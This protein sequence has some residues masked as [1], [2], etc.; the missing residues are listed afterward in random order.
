MS[1]SVRKEK[2]VFDTAKLSEFNFGDPEAKNDPL[3]E[4]CPLT[5]KGVKEFLSGAK[6]IVLGERGVGK[7][8]L[9]KL[10]SEGI[11]NFSTETPEKKKPRKQIIVAI[12]DD[13]EYQ[14]IANVV[15]ERFE[16]Q[17]KKKF[18]KNRLFWEI[19]IL[20]KTIAK[21]LE[22]DSEN[23]ELT[24][25]L[26][27]F[28]AVLGVTVVEG[29]SIG[30][31]LSSLKLTGGVKLDQAGSLTPTLSVES[32]KNGIVPR[33]ITDHEINALRDRVVKYLKPRNYSVIVMIDKIDDFVVGLDYENQKL[34]I[35]ALLECVQC[36]NLPQIKLK[37]FLRA[38]LF[39]RMNFETT[40]Y[41][42]ISP[43]LVRLTWTEGDIKEFVARRLHYNFQKCGVELQY[44]SAAG[45]LLD[46]DP[47]IKDQFKDL[48]RNKPKTVREAISLVGTAL[49]LSTKVRWHVFRNPHRSARKTNL[50]DDVYLAVI[51]S[52]FPSKIRH[53]NMLCKEEEM[54][55][56]KFL[57]THFN[58]GGAT[59][60]PRLVLLFLQHVI[61]ESVSYYSKN[62]DRTMIPRDEAYEYEV[63]LKDHVSAGYR[64]T[65]D[66]ARKTISHLNHDWHSFVDRL[67]VST[68]SPKS[69]KR[70]SLDKIKQFIQWDKN[71]HEFARFIAF[72]SH[73][74]LLIAENPAAKLGD[75]IYSFPL[76]LQHCCADA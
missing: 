22:N 70:L 20:G 55:I 8:A 5:I 1:N 67:Y 14:N 56:G 34:N 69:C 4:H 12:D 49:F 51:T 65:Q 59:P 76:I 11:Y 19:T 54:S 47:S 24:A 44:R 23:L 40:G 71:D 72:Y 45:A 50:E 2:G 38:D 68:F 64:K 62:P 63:I 28:Q 36:Y 9:F 31:F 43:K 73:V 39:E 42:K 58:L 13:F 57:G 41:D 29:F 61:E 16:S 33:K 3:L 52:I 10:V 48:L 30:N 37:I 18:G 74:G 17:G 60:N 26:K 53:K 27:D 32:S 35:Q 6:S 25:L 21:L 66:I 75:R 7:S 15:E 46:V